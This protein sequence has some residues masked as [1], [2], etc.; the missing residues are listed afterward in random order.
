MTK[1]WSLLR[2]K[3]QGPAGVLHRSAAGH[4]GDGQARRGDGLYAARPS[5]ATET[6]RSNTSYQSIMMGS[7][8]AGVWRRMR[9]LNP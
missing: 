5:W 2:G 1:R 9:D 7:V 8:C 4:A 6:D 3:R